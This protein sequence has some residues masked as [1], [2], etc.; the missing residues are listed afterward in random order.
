MDEF[1]LAAERLIETAS[2]LNDDEIN[3]ACKELREVCVDHDEVDARFR[4]AGKKVEALLRD[5]LATAVR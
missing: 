5:R 1:R 4:A 2:S 3:E